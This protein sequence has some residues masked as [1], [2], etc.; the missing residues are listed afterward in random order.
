MTTSVD[1]IVEL[2]LAL[3]R[4]ERANLADRLV[5]SLDPL[6]DEQ[7]RSLWALEAKRRVEELRSG[8]VEAIP[9]EEVFAEMRALSK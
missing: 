6:D 4:E 5:E 1:R 9:A 7:V 3:T 2:A 8:A